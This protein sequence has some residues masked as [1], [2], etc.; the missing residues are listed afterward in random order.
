MAIPGP[1]HCRGAGRSAPHQA[2][3]RD[4]G[5][6]AGPADG[7]WWLSHETRHRAEP[8][9]GLSCQPGGGTSSD[10]SCGMARERRGGARQQ[11]ACRDGDSARPGTL[12]PRLPRARGAGSFTSRFPGAEVPVP[13]AAMPWPRRLP[14]PPGSSDTPEPWKRME[15]FTSYGLRTGARSG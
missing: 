9:P 5:W 1:A 12:C 14:V 4:Q 6:K 11:C 8:L 7:I 2:P 13:P 15:I 3:Q 10:R